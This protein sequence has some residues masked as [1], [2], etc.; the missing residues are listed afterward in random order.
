MIYRPDPD[1][2]NEPRASIWFR[3]YYPSLDFNEDEGW[4]GGGC[5]E[6]RRT[7]CVGSMLT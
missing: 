5:E 4:K 3:V 7:L 1:M 6:V 2:N